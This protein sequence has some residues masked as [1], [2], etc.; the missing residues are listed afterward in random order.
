MSITEL[1]FINQENASLVNVLQ[2]LWHIVTISPRDVPISFH[3]V[4][5]IWI[6]GNPFFLA[7]ISEPVDACSGHS[8][9][10]QACGHDSN[11]GENLKPH[12]DTITKAK[13][14]LPGPLKVTWLNW[15]FLNLT[16]WL[17]KISEIGAFF[18]MQEICSDQFKKCRKVV[19]GTFH[20]LFHSFSQQR[21]KVG[22][23]ISTREIRKLSFKKVK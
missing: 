6:M 7:P 2:T 22:I 4:P 9:D 21:F 12:R 14:F 3:Q 8:Q 13:H 5:L 10:E 11:P 16:I 23:T 19:P 17:G 15:L 18:K 20:I 1:F